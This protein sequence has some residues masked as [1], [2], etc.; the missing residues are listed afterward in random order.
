MPKVTPDREDFAQVEKEH[1]KL[2]KGASNEEQAKRYRLAQIVK[3]MREPVEPDDVAE[4][5][6]LTEEQLEAIVTKYREA[7]K[8]SH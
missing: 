4:A 8:R 3:L 2:P 1:G 7:K 5:L 6:G